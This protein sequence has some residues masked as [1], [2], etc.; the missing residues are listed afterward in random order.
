[1]DA[2]NLMAL[3]K[4]AER[5]LSA[6]TWGYYYGGADDEVTLRRNRAA[7]EDI[8]LRYRVLVDVGERDLSATVLGSKLELPVL[9]APTAFHK[10]AHPDGEVAT[11]RAAT[12]VGTTMVLSTLSTTGVEEVVSAAERDI[13]FQLYVY[14]DRG[15]TEALV[16]RVHAAGCK[17]LVLTVDAPLLGRRE[18]DIRTGFALPEGMGI[19]NM[20]AD[21]YARVDAAEG[22]S[23][24]AAYFARLLD[25]SLCWKDLDW[26]RS[27]SPMPVLVKGIVRADDARRSIEHGADGIIVSNHGGRQLDTSVATIEALPDVAAEVGDEALLLLD[28]GIRRG[29]DILKALALGAHAVLIGRPVLWGLAAGGQAGVEHALSLLRTELDLAM[30]LAG[31]ATIEDIRAD[32]IA[33]KGR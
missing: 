1:M 33:P 23:G 24:L 6:M 25:P 8:S 11:A 17:A 30:A 5:E 2:L 12:A 10:L 28:G 7:Y 26:L 19:E 31:C 20:L 16:Q 32:L 9:V 27:I 4:L 18:R 3:E 13:W 14:C 29:T 21:G 22:D 15:A